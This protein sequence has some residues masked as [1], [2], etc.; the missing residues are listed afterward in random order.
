MKIV[1][2]ILVLVVLSYY[3]FHFIQVMV[4]MKNKMVFPSTD[5]EMAAIRKGPQKALDLPHYS[6][7]KLGIIFYSVTLLFVTSMFIAGLL[8][9]FVWSFYLM[10]F[11]PLV[12]VRDLFNMFGFVEDGVLSGS[13][14][15]PWEKIKSYS[16]V[17]IDVNH[18]FY[19]HSKEVNDRYELRIK[20]RLGTYSCVVLTDEVKEK[21]ERI[22]QERVA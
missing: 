22:L 3:T 4:K 5:E 12:H 13:R 15:I 1:M 18:R 11:V 17:R 20:S 14:F 2:N 9:D 7:Q 8:Q 16:F 6:K 10:I 21:M 19:G